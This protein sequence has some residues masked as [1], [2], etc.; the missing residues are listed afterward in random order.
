M[1]C[2]CRKSVCPGCREI[3]LN[4]ANVSNKVSDALVKLGVPRGG[5]IPDL[6]Q[7]PTRAWPLDDSKQRTKTVGPASTVLMISKSSRSPWADGVEGNIPDD[8]HWADMI[9]P[10]SV[11]VIQAPL[12][13][14]AAVGGLIGLRLQSRQARAVVVCGRVRDVE[15]LHDLSIPVICPDA[16]LHCWHTG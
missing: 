9:E 15:E 11:A 8:K 12:S 14:A 5:F 13:Y 4:I 7:R 10:G 3:S 2:M 6:E 1:R 16:G